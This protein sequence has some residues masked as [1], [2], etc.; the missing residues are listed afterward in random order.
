MTRHSSV[1]MSVG[2]EVILGR[3][4]GGD[5]ASWANANHYWAEK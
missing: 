2:G 4:K 3:G 5:D 1:A